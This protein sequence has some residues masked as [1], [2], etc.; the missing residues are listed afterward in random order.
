[1]K[2]DY[3]YAD[4]MLGLQSNKNNIKRKKKC[5]NCKG[6]GL[7]P[8]ITTDFDEHRKQCPQ[9]DGSGA[10]SRSVDNEGKLIKDCGVCEGLGY[11]GIKKT[12]KAKQFEYL[13]IDMK[14]PLYFKMLEICLQ[15]RISIDEFV[16]KA[17]KNEMKGVK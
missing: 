12:K 14:E 9:C 5:S 1:M 3:S 4:E 16:M 15:E 10:V 8:R 17:I 11:V 13:S 6:K 2:K 7:M